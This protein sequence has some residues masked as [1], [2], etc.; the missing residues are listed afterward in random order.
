MT[1]STTRSTTRSM[2]QSSTAQQLAA[3]PSYERCL[4]SLDARLSA[5]QQIPARGALALLRPELCAYAAIHTAPPDGELGPVLGVST[6]GAGPGFLER[7]RVIALAAGVDDAVLG[8]LAA[9]AGF[10]SYRRALVELQWLPRAAGGVATSITTSFLRRV[11]LDELADFLREQGASAAALDDL[12]VLAP[13]LGKDTPHAISLSIRPGL[14]AHLQ[15]SFSQHATAATAPAL[16]QR[17]ARVLGAAGLA[18]A[19]LALWVAH[20]DATLAPHLDPRDVWGA[21]VF[22]TIGLSP[23]G[24]SPGLSL[25]YPAVI[26]STAARWAAAERVSPAAALRAG[27]AAAVAAA[28][29]GAPALAHLRLHFTP[30]LPAPTLEWLAVPHAKLPGRTG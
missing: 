7:I 15:L 26:A 14:G 17:L 22:V 28:A 18:P 25:E 16:R 21:T 20:H 3:P 11:P 30:H 10:C 24:L 1:R 13:M 4:L 19:A 12:A 5:E 6:R 27:H 9:L 8:E 23:E 2:T 29:V